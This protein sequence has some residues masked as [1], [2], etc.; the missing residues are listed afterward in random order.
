MQKIKEMI[1]REIAR[2]VLS[3]K[4]DSYRKNRKSE[5][6]V[7]DRIIH[8]VQARRWCMER[9]LPYDDTLLKQDGYLLE[10]IR[11]MIEF[12]IEEKLKEW[13]Y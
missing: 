2:M 9:L 10:Q 12:E 4:S 7:I 6:M 3:V 8:E 13:G 1:A 5:R 11:T